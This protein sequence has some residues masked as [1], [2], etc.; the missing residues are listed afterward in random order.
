MHYYAPGL[1]QRCLTDD[2]GAASDTDAHASRQAMG[3]YPEADIRAAV[4]GVKRVYFVVFQRAVDEYL[5][6][7]EEN[8]PA[9]GWLS[10]D[11]Q[12]A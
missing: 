3:M 4:S 6:I 2:P 7:G 9:L 8:H 11:Y 10:G 5:A 12:L 1:H